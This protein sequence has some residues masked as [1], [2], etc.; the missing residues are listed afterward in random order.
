MG[1]KIKI[2]III[3]I[4]ALLIITL[5]IGINV[6]LSNKSNEKYGDWITDNE[7]LYD[8]AIE[9]LR[10]RKYKTTYDKD[11]EDYQI[12]YDYEG[13]GIKEKDNQKYA[14]MYILE[15]SYYVKHGKIRSSES[16]C[17][18]YKFIF[19]NNEVI[20]YENPKDGS[21]Y[22]NSIREIFP[23]DIENKVKRYEFK[24]AKLKKKVEEH[25]S[26]LEST[27]IVHT[28]Y[29]EDIIVAYGIYG[30]NITK[31][32]AN[33]IK[34]KCI[35]GYGDIYE[36][37]IPCNEN[38]GLL[39]EIESIDKNIISK[40]QGNKIASISIEDLN[41]IK[42]NLNNLKEEYSNTKTINEDM[43]LSF[44]KVSHKKNND[45]NMLV[46]DYENSSLMDLLVDT[47]NVRK[48]NTSEASKNIFNI[49]T[50]YNLSI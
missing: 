9:Y 26:Y 23:D 5:I 18:P 50:K 47:Y 32:E 41:T 7:F 38:Q 20:G 35:D 39:V 15:E 27:L 11:K 46:L 16:S 2:A 17:M 24:D 42:N 12:F 4:I 40:Y 29:D 30:G 8:K 19:E 25:Y 10:E 22:A 28:D 21:E 14:Y 13:F 34:G 1:K 49:L 48:E 3:L 36:Y 45:N 37:K 43:Q 33:T 31:S 44:V 6:N